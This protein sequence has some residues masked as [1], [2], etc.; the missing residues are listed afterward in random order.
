MMGLLSGGQGFETKLDLTEEKEGLIFWRI[1]YRENILIYQRM[2]KDYYFNKL[3]PL[4]DKIIKI[5]NSL[6]TNFYLTGGTASSRGYLNHRF[7]DDLDFFVNDDDKFGLWNDRLVH[8]ITATKSWGVKVEQRDERF[9]RVALTF[10]EIFLKIEMVN[11]VPSYIGAVKTDKI[12]GRLD[13]PENILAN[14]VSAV[15]DR[16]EPKD[17]ADIW[18]FCAQMN[19][20][21]KNALNNAESKAAGIFPP[22]LARV[23]CSATREDWEAVRWIKRPECD[24]F[25]NKLH[26]LG[27]ELVFE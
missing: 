11:D 5:I 19:L 1:S 21:L 26:T 15:V 23:L 18:G 14:K 7:S 9:C 2:N 17:L 24:I 10:D 22:D 13:N 12:L 16:K 4:Q 8:S 3:Y 25:L 27:E 20:S 6:G